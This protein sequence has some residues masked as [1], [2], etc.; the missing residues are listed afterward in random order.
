[1]NAAEQETG[2]HVLIVEDDELVGDGIKT[3]LEAL[4]QTPDW[5][6]SAAAADTAV[7]MVDFDVVVLD[8]G[9]PDEDG[10]ALLQR[11]RRRSVDVP[12]LILTA[13]DAVPDRVAGLAAGADDYLTKP[14]DLRELAA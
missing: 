7:E 13:R 5:V 10:M 8:L 11:W 3:G 4:G 6:R 14:F 9:L 12:I 2:M 1:M